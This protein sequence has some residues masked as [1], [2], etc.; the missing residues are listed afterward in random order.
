M[1]S[2]VP[3]ECI[4]SEIFLLV[5]DYKHLTDRSK[6][7]VEL[8]HHAVVELKTA[9]AFCSMYSLVV[10][11]VD[12]Y[13]LAAGIAVACIIYGIIYIE[14]RR[15]ARH[16]SLVLRSA[17]KHLLKGREETYILCEICAAGLILEKYEAF[18]CSLGLEKM[19]VIILDRSDD[20]IHIAVLH[21]H[22]CHV[23]GKIIVSA[24]G[25]YTLGK[26]CAHAFVVSQCGSL[27]QK[28]TYLL[29]LFLVLVTVPYGLECAVLVATDYGI[30]AEL[31]R[32][33]ECFPLFHC[34]IL[35]II[36]TSERLLAISFDERSVVIEMVP[37]TVVDEGIVLCITVRKC[38][39]DAF[40]SEGLL[41][42]Q[43]VHD[44]SCL[45]EKI[46]YLLVVIR[47]C[48]V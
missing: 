35:R 43:S 9:C 1:E 32:I 11:K 31:V 10:R 19:I 28:G 33:V 27:F 38:I 7:L 45:T 13:G 48:I 3:E 36:L 34:H 12:C 6:Y 42:E 23:A 16:E 24:E 29:Q 41:P 37:C 46:Y 40:I 15:C 8:G 18:I 17:R 4:S 39:D 22:P 25:L 14:V 26:I 20:D 30:K 47:K 2:H 44:L 21:V 5:L